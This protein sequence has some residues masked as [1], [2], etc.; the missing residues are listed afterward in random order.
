MD[1][2]VQHRTNERKTGGKKFR[3][4]GQYFLPIALTFLEDDDNY[5]YFFCARRRGKTVNGN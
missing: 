1:L 2:I 4:V 5:V 3:Y